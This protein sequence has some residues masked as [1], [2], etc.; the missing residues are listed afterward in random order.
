MTDLYDELL[1]GDG[2]LTFFYSLLWAKTGKKHHDLQGV[3]IP[4]TI[5]YSYSK[6][7]A[8][9]FTNKQGNIRKKNHSRLNSGTIEESF[10]RRGVSCSGTVAQYITRGPPPPAAPTL[11]IDYLNDN[12]L[13]EFLLNGDK[14]DGLLQLFFDPAHNYTA[15]NLQNSDLLLTYGA[16]C[17]TLEKRVNNHRMDDNSIPLCDRMNTQHFGHTAVHPATSTVEK[18]CLKVAEKIVEHLHIIFRYSVTTMVLVFKPDKHDNVQ[19]LWC[20]SMRLCDEENRARALLVTVQSP[21]LTQ[22]SE[23]EQNAKTQQQQARHKDLVRQRSEWHT[24]NEDTTLSDVA[25]CCLCLRQLKREFL[26]QTSQRS[27]LYGMQALFKVMAISKLKSKLGFQQRD[28]ALAMC[29]KTKKRIKR[30]RVGE[31]PQFA[32]DDTDTDSMGM[33]LGSYDAI[34]RAGND[35][36]LRFLSLDSKEFLPEPPQELLNSTLL[37]CTQCLD[38]LISVVSLH[39]KNPDIVRKALRRPSPPRA[40]SHLGFTHES[41]LVEQHSPAERVA[42]SVTPPPASTTTLPVLPVSRAVVAMDQFQPLPKSLL[43]KA[44]NTMAA[45]V[46]CPITPDS[47]PR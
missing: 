46:F 29:T 40:N 13:R 15:I 9:Y 10:I 23:K 35:Q 16:G 32:D 14:P 3:H 41:N 42:V 12:E 8:W 7:I 38:A 26:S 19:L 43:G 28:V 45:P 21:Q 22:I 25:P 33:T 36:F 37:C 1:R 4:D 44:N 17:H 20:H 5:V 34:S 18:R 47:T 31:I 39:D 27:I 6:P 24:H 2:I 11:K 30:S